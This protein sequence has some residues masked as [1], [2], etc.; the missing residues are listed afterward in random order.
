MPGETAI[1]KDADNMTK[2]EIRLIAHTITGKMGA[3]LATRM[4][5]EDST[6]VIYYFYREKIGAALSHNAELMGDL[7]VD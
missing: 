6:D 1:E 3:T 4:K 5:T 2:T 7:P